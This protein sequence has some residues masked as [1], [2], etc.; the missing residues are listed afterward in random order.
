MLLAII[1]I[2]IVS[3]VLFYASYSIRAGI[4]IRSI[5]FVKNQENGIA[6]TF[7]D[8][9][10]PVMTPRVLDVLKKH[11]AKATCFIIGS[12]A[13]EYPHIVKRIK[14]E[15]HEIGNHSHYHRRSFPMQSTTTIRQEIEACSRVIKEITGDDVTLFRPPF[16]V[17]NAMIANAVRQTG[18]LSTGWSIRSLDTMGHETQ[19]VTNRVTRKLKS[20]SIVLLHDNR[21]GASELIESIMEHTQRNKFKTLTISELINKQKTR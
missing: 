21:S 5:C 14:E 11:G 7:D 20:G 13:R 12:K 2:L 15:G 10:D 9:P 4:Y 19:R 16:G 1:T 3:W 8:G 6:L 17:T 18:L